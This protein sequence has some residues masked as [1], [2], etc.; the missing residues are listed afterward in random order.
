MSSHLGR[1]RAPHPDFIDGSGHCDPGGVHGDAD[2][3]FIGMGRTITGVCQAA[4]PIS[5]EQKPLL[6]NMR[7]HAEWRLQSG[8]SRSVEK[9]RV[10][11]FSIN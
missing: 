11:R 8:T 2:E 10:K 6:G 4:H 1:V 5:L 9:R 7:P 3:G